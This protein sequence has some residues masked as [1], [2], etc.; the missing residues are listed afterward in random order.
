M[1]EK[2][3]NEAYPEWMSFGTYPNGDANITNANDEFNARMS[4]AAADLI[5]EQHQKLYRAF[6]RTALAFAEAAPEAFEKFW[7]HGG[8]TAEQSPQ[9]A[10]SAAVAA[11]TTN[12]LTPRRMSE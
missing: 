3:I 5:L 2:Y 10:A 6:E 12:G 11:L 4:P 8:R 7:Y 1:R 9:A